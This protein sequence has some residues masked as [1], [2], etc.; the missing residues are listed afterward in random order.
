MQIDFYVL[1]GKTANKA[2]TLTVN[3]LTDELSVDV[4]AQQAQDELLAFVCRLTETVLAKSEQTLVILDDDAHR[5]KQLDDR[6]WTV[7]ATS[8][9]PHELCLHDA[10]L[11]NAKT[12]DDTHERQGN[13]QDQHEQATDKTINEAT[14]EKVIHDIDTGKK[15]VKA[16]Q[17]NASLTNHSIAP[18]IL[19]NQLPDGFTGVVLNLA[20]APLPID[21]LQAKRQTDDNPEKAD[22]NSQINDAKAFKGLVVCPSR[23]LE[24]IP[25]D[26]SNKQKGR[27][28]YKH[29]QTLG[30][31]LGYHPVS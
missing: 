30:Y 28:K 22:K 13:H 16:K 17:D 6:L 2:D 18:V 26:D 25:A 29:Y 24:I 31:Q 23:L 15:E 10:P 14:H 5:L 4:L 1:T 9:I 21:D 12:T 11:Y 20:D 7:S 19:T 8:F 27:L 3:T